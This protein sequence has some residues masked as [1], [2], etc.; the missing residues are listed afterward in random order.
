MSGR[1]FATFILSLLAGMVLGAVLF[2]SYY[3]V[4]ERILEEYN[5]FLMFL[6]AIAFFVVGY[7]AGSRGNAQEFSYRPMFQGNVQSLGRDGEKIVMLSI[8]RAGIVREK[9]R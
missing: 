1:V 9:G 5:F 4:S 3:E 6:P 8:K 2:N 7:F